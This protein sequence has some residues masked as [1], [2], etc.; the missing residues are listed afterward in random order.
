MA[1]FPYLRQI[2]A[3]L[4]PIQTNIREKILGPLTVGPVESTQ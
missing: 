3:Q 4:R 2:L 1:W